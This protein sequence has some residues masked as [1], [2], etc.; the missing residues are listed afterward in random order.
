MTEESFERSNST[1]NSPVSGLVD[2]RGRVEQ[3]KVH[4]SVKGQNVM[5]G[6]RT[7]AGVSVW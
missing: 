4:L 5:V 2:P 1:N 6:R 3:Q 7:L